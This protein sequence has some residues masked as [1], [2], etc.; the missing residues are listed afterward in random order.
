MIDVQLRL[1]GRQIPALQWRGTY[2][3]DAG[4][5]RWIRLV[6]SHAA[7]RF[8][9]KISHYDYCPGTQTAPL[10]AVTAKGSAGGF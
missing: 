4:R 9:W 8:S 1:S 7:Q 2:I 3:D 5:R 6:A 10:F